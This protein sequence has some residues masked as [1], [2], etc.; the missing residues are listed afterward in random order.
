MVWNI[1]HAHGHYE[2]Y[3][4]E[5]RFLFSADSH[6]EAMEELAQWENETIA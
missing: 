1:L 3:T 5:G 6:R 2:V 4:A